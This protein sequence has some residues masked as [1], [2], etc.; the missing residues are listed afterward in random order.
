MAEDPFRM[1]VP[2]DRCR[3]CGK[4]D[5]PILGSKVSQS[6]WVIFILLLVLFLPLCWLGLLVR[7]KYPVC[8]HCGYKMG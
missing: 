2:S 8:R 1:S 4:V 6:G 3:D 5:D 7:E